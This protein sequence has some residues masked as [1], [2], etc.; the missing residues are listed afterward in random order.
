M[1]KASRSPHKIPVPLFAVAIFLSALLLFQIQPLI[2]KLILPWFGGSAAVWTTCLMFFQLALLG[3]YAWAHFLSKLPHARQ[4]TVHIGLIAISLAFLPILPSARWKPGPGLDPLP[5]ILG[6]LVATIGLPYFVLSATGPLLQSWY[7]RTSQDAI[8]WRLF[9]L[10]N[11]GSMLGLLT[12]PVLVEPYLSSRR[13]AWMWSIAYCG[14]AALCATVAWR[15]RAPSVSQ[16][17]ARQS[18][19]SPSEP[20]LTVCCG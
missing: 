4:R 10:S 1:A 14:F 20:L 17:R 12:Y 6:L 16:A 8:P 11:A 13:Q 3:G 7:S 2:A 15:S 9:A 5:L 19:R 18:L